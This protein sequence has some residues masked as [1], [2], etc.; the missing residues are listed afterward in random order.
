MFAAKK[1]ESGNFLLEHVSE[2]ISKKD[3]YKREKKYFKKK[4]AKIFLFFYSEF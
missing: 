1:F 3:E 4:K 2:F